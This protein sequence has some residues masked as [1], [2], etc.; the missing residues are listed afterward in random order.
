MNAE[1]FKQYLKKFN[2]AEIVGT[3]DITIFPDEKI[4]ALKDMFEIIEKCGAYVRLEWYINDEKKIIYLNNAK[5]ACTS[6]KSIIMELEK[7]KYYES[8]HQILQ[9]RALYNVLPESYKDYFKFTFVRNP[10]ERLVSCYENKYHTDKKLIGI[11]KEILG[12]NFFDLYYVRVNYLLGYLDKD[13]GFASFA[14]KIVRVPNE[15]AD[16]HF[17]SQYFMTYRNDK[18]LVDYVGKFEKLPES[19]KNIQNQD[20]LADLHVY[21]KTNKGNWMDYYNHETAKLVHDYYKKDFEV[22][23]YEKEYDKLIK[24]LDGKEK[25]IK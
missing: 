12:T 22:F 16:R 7:Q 25:K 19:F 5:V 3:S 15:L 13:E 10:F 1:Q 17:V 18:C 9:K 21:N 4:M 23:N 20:Q 14:K 24:Y 2:V 11:D 8:V 6:F